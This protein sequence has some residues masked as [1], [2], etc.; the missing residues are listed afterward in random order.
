MSLSAR[1]RTVTY[2]LALHDRSSDLACRK[3]V[4]SMRQGSTAP[5]NGLK[6][7]ASR[8]ALFFSPLAGA[9]EPWRIDRKSTRLNSSHVASPYA[10]FCL[11]KKT[12]PQKG[13]DQSRP[14]SRP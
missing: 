1:A 4:V 13:K 12:P 10:A 3:A 8:E 14:D 11:K 6:N 7:N 5:A 2:A 9:V